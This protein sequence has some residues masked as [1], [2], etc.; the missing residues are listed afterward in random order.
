MERN[1]YAE[2]FFVLLAVAALVTVV[3]YPKEILVEL[4]REIFYVVVV[5]PIKSILFIPVWVIGTPIL[6]FGTKYKW[7]STPTIKKLLDFAILEDDDRP[8][9]SRKNLKVDFRSGEKYIFVISSNKDVKALVISFNDVFSNPYP[10]DDFKIDLK[11]GQAM[12]S[13]SNNIGFYDFHLMVQHIN[14]E[15]GEKSS[16]GIYRS[17]KLQ[18]FIFKDKDT[19][20]NLIGF[21][22]DKRFFS[23]HMLDDLDEDQHLRLNQKLNID[24]EWVERWVG[25]IAR[26]D[27]FTLLD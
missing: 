23:I 25:A 26:K 8:Y 3:K 12:I 14:D 17:A 11:D 6:Y 15:L 4:P 18:Y 9:P 24:T 19:L 5:K 13:F 22:S 10:A 27:N 1:Y 2:G 20:N 16:F 7:K 21:T